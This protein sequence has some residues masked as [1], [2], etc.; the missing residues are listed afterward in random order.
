MNYSRR[1]LQAVTLPDGCYILGGFDGYNYLNSVER[2][3]DV[4]DTWISI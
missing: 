4:N 3:D 2:Y 1:S